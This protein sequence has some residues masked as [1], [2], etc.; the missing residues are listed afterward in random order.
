MEDL[1]N[2]NEPQGELR[3]RR[4]KK[5]VTESSN[6][7][8]DTPRYKKRRKRRSVQNSPQEEVPV[9]LIRLRY[10]GVLGVIVLGFLIALGLSYTMA[11]HNSTTFKNKLVAE[12]EARSGAEVFLS[13]LVVQRKRAKAHQLVVQWGDSTPYLQRLELNKLSANYEVGGLLGGGWGEL[14]FAAEKG[15]L[16][17][18]SSQT[19]NERVSLGVANHGITK[20]FEGVRCYGM[21]VL[22][23]N[24]TFVKKTSARFSMGQQ[25]QAISLVGGTLFG[26]DGARIERGVIELFN[27]HLSVDVRLKLQDLGEVNLSADVGYSSPSNLDMQLDV[28]ELDSR[29]LIGESCASMLSGS[30]SG[31]N[32]SLFVSDILELEYKH[33][34]AVVSDSIE[35]RNLP[36]FSIIAD[37]LLKGWYRK[38]VFTRD[39]SMVVEK[40]LSGDVYI[41]DLVM[42]EPGRIA[43][44]GAITHIQATQKLG[45]VLRIGIPEI[46]SED[47]RKY[48]GNNAFTESKRGY[49][50]QTVHLSG[51]IENPSDDLEQRVLNRR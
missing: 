7:T 12:I 1:P 18:L 41:K 8:E 28:F 40:E 16:S 44:E 37:A 15:Q 50:W 45:G 31:N 46:H 24:S 5:R 30:W 2:T 39:G 3:R 43:I 34:I 21:D 6:I 36:C 10:F 42:E 26:D 20:G 32:G 49:L 27:D 9:W 25:R 35:L 51:T 19:R 48:F 17:L 22:W 29:Y 47:L 14:D 38:P 23:D 11:Y 13:H 4:I 33:K